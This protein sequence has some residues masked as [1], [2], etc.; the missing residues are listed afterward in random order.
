[1]SD[2]LIGKISYFKTGIKQTAPTLDM[3]PIK[4]LEIIRDGEY[5][6]QLLQLRD[7][8]NKSMRQALKRDLGYFTFSGTFK[9]R[10][11]NKLIKHSGLICI[12]LD[13]LDLPNPEDK[14]TRDPERV[15]QIK[16]Q[17]TKDPYILAMFISPSG[18]GLKLLIRI[19][20]E[21]HLATFRGLERYFAE[22]YQLD[23][24]QSGKDV[25]RACYVSYDPEIYIN[26]KSEPFTHILEADVQIDSD[27]GEVFDR[28]E[29]VE[30]LPPRIKKSYARAVWLVE[31]IE[32]SDK[33]DAEKDITAGYQEWLEIGMALAVFGEAGREL[34]HR[35][36][37]FNADY[38]PRECDAK[39]TDLIKTSRFDS[40]AKFFKAAKDAGFETRQTKTAE[41]AAPEDADTMRREW[42]W[43]TPDGMEISEEIKEHA[44]N[45]GFVE[46]KRGL[47]VAKHDFK[48]KKIE[49]DNISNYT[50]RPLFLIASKSDPKRLYEI[51]NDLNEKVVVD[52]P[53]NAFKNMSNFMEIMEVQGNYLMQCR[54]E[55]FHKLK[56]KWFRDERK[57]EEIKTLGYHRDDFYAFSNGLF[58]DKKFHGIDE[59][60]MITKKFLDEEGHEY[61][62]HYFIPAMSEIYK[63]EEAEYETEKNFLYVSRNITW[64]E[65]SDLFCKV[66]GDNGK[67]AILYI[68]AALFRDQIYGHF[69]NFPH[70]LGFG[71]RGTGK[72]I[73]GWSINY[74][75]GKERKPFNLNSGT[76][77]GFYRTFAQFNNAIVWFD[78][79][80]NRID[81]KRMEDLKNAYDG[82]GHIKG[83]WSA[84][85]N[86]NRT[87]STPVRSGCY[88]SG[89]EL[90]ISNPALF[91]RTILLEFTK[92]DFTQEEKDM[93]SKLIDIEKP[94]L[95]RITAGLTIF[96]EKIQDQFHE[97]YDQVHRRMKKHFE[98]MD[99]VV[100][101]RLIHNNAIL[102]AMYEV[103]REELEFPFNDKEIWNI[104]TN[105]LYRHNRLF[106][107]SEET[108][109]F[110]DAVQYLYTMGM[111]HDEMDFCVKYTSSVMLRLDRS[112]TTKKEF[113]EPKELLFVSLS[114]MHG[115]YMKT[116]REQGSKG[117]DKESLCHYLEH[118][119]GYIGA[120]NSVN[121][122]KRKTSGYV[123]DYEVIKQIGINLK[124]LND[125][126]IGEGEDVEFADMPLA[127]QNGSS[128]KEQF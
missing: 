57:A 120:F 70:L 42:Y 91:S 103:L 84:G 4:A 29:S 110:W 77:P 104:I 75:F 17:L 96:R 117:M 6:D 46:Y 15:L 116:L 121:F 52:M 101:E 82:A 58:Y 76:A 63:D 28:A 20:G 119:R 23:I 13:D 43:Q 32:Q 54:K 90:P 33:S 113:E 124:Q 22:Q 94:G 19:N 59:Y 18:N 105:K 126:G 69:K 122:G 60:G 27:T 128:N 48:N 71:P 50:V 66:H 112:Q 65:W 92:S 100:M 86:S 125:T 109:Q 56:I 88:I 3:F 78:E 97:K 25:S 102:L 49:L 108:N 5:K 93:A 53:A 114:R 47:W 118:S 2:H 39:F 85:G 111:I 80:D 107:K 37:Q 35:I 95:S 16:E 26:D 10:H 14:E 51:K 83:D 89:Q 30:A 67:V 115:L 21:H 106:S 40:P 11:A 36:S 81:L 74:M 62:R 31:Q 8:A 123:F 38:K 64:K 44:L 24:D 72:S 98:A 34:F 12:D 99:V 7:T 41:P 73:L 79:F 9:K 45:H 61:E 87:T 55:D 1:M 127:A 68:I